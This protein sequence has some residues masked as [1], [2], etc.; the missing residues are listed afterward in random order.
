[1]AFNGGEDLLELDFADG[2]LGV[3]RKPEAGRPIVSDD[4]LEFRGLNDFL[5]CHGMK[6]DS[7]GHV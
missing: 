6:N 3:V 1:M 7:K 5:Y 4:R 2:V